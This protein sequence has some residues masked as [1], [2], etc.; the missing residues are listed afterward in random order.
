MEAE[1]STALEAVTRQ[2]VETEQ[3][4]KTVLAVVTYRGCELGIVL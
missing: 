2:P 3:I 1:R 4:E